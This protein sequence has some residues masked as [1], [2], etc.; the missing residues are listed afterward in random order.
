MSIAGIKNAI[1]KVAKSKPAT[2]ASKAIGA[3][4]IGSVIYDSHV[5]AKE[6]AICKDQ[7][8]SANRFF[9][10]YD[11]YMISH[12]ESATVAKLKSWWF[13]AQQSFSSFHFANRASGY[14]GGFCKTVATNLPVLALGATSLF[15]KNVGKVASAL[16]ILG[17]IKTF[18]YDIAGIGKKDNDS[19]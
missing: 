19:L 16:L 5:N 2:V 13:D 7:L 9:N 3:I 17:G 10:E 8:K 1:V 18:L 15:T 12:R 4:A 11:N 6:D 14:L